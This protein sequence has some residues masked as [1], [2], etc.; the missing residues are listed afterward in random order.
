M[1][2]VLWALGALI[3]GYPVTGL[4]LGLVLLSIAWVA[5]G[6]RL[7]VLWVCAWGWPFLLVFALWVSGKASP[8]GGRR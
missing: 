8:A 7:G 3:L 4:L 1:M 2:V 6:D 5:P